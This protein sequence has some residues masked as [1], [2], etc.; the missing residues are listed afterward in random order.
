MKNLKIIPLSGIFLI[1]FLTL[2]VDLAYAQNQLWQT[3]VGEPAPA[4]IIDTGDGGSGGSGGSG[5]GS[6]KW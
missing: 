6:G 2:S 3:I 4:E 5:G 1:L